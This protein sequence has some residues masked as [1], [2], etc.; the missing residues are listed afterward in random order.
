M[1]QLLYEQTSYVAVVWS[2]SL[3]FNTCEPA[4]CK[5][6]GVWR[7]TRTHLVQKCLSQ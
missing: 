1:C 6:C 2:C 3:R 7:V 4:H 5:C